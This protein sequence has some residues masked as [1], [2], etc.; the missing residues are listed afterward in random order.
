MKVSWSMKWASS[1]VHSSWLMWWLSELKN[2]PTVLTKVCQHTVKRNFR[3]SLSTAH[4]IRSSNR[5]I[6]LYCPALVL[7]YLLQRRTFSRNDYSPCAVCLGW[8]ISQQ[9]RHNSLV[10]KLFIFPIITNT[11]LRF[12]LSG[13]HIVFCFFFFNIC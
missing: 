1:K 9:I 10:K 6:C 2:N 8:I 3:I 5:Q 7:S 11:C 13:Q 4:Y 12:T